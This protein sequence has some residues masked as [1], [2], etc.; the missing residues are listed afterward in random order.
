MLGGGR[1]GLFNPD[2]GRVVVAV[3]AG[4]EKADSKASKPKKSFDVLSL[5]AADNDEALLVEAPPNGANGSDPKGSL[6]KASLEGPPPPLL[7]CLAFR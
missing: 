4:D 7:C 2:F 6:A 5:N 3:G 1:N